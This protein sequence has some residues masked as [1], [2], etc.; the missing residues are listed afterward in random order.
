MITGGQFG[1]V[2]KLDLMEMEIS[3]LLV[4][5]TLIQSA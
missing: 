5:R 1:E 3:M 4:N 2:G